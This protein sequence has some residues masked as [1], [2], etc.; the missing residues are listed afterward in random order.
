MKASKL[1][2]KKQ[3]QQIY[4][5]YIYLKKNRY[6][7]QNITFEKFLTNTIKLNFKK[8]RK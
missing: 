5:E 2:S 8:Q 6:I 4:G 3:R 1:I 7:N